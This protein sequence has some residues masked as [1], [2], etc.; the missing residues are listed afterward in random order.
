MPLTA[1][2][3]PVKESF[4]HPTQLACACTFFPI[5]STS[6]MYGMRAAQ[7]V[8]KEVPSAHWGKMIPIFLHRVLELFVGTC[9]LAKSLCSTGRWI[10]PKALRVWVVIVRSQWV[11]VAYRW[12]HGTECFEL[13]IISYS[14]ELCSLKRRLLRCAEGWGSLP[15]DRQFFEPLCICLGV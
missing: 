6:G 15:S 5:F 13:S 2:S 12:P 7:I 10:P 9:S 11:A 1:N 4:V 8:P 3:Y 14:F